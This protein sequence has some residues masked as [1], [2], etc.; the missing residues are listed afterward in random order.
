M[1]RPVA[2]EKSRAIPVSAED[3]FAGTLP[4]PLPTIFRRRYGPIPPI[5]Q[6]GDQTGAWDTPGQARKV[7]LAGGGSMRE[8]LTKVDPPRSFSYT[9]TDI[10]GPL[11]P[12]VSW[13]E[14]EWLFT[15]KGTGTEVTWRWTIHPRFQ[16]AAPLIPVFGRLWQGYARQALEELSGQLVR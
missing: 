1:A 11:T 10:R 4:I 6:V 16:L 12:L 8:E 3:A 9:L 14:G 2:V 13:V 7:L 15:P 5:K